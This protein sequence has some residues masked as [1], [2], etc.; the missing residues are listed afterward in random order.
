MCLP[1]TYHRIHALHPTFRQLTLTKPS[2]QHSFPHPVHWR[3]SY[4]G[5]QWLEIEVVGLADHPVSVARQGPAG[6]GPD[7]GLA[8]SQAADEVG[9]QLRQVGHHAVHAALGDGAQHQDAWL[10]DLPLGVEQGLL[11]DGQQHGQ[12]VLVEH[13]GQDVQSRRRTLSCGE[14][15][16]VWLFATPSVRDGTKKNWKSLK[17]GLGPGLKGFLH[18]MLKKY[19]ISCHSGDQKRSG[20][21]A[22]TDTHIYNFFF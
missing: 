15:A 1:R 19:P 11:E 14:T 17:R 16:K 7:Q 8:V 10:L 18:L 20:K 21:K 5:H 2:N 6:D 12:D 4:L 3:L 22:P 9:H 13:V